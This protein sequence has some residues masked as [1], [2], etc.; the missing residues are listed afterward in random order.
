MRL[1]QKPNSACRNLDTLQSFLFHP[2]SHQP[3]VSIILAGYFSS[4][5]KLFTAQQLSGMSRF[6]G[7]F[8]LPAM[9]FKTLAT[10]DFS[11][12]DYAFV[13]GIFLAKVTMAMLV[14]ASTLVFEYRLGPG[15]R[16][17]EG[18]LRGERPEGPSASAAR[19]SVGIS[20]AMAL[21]GLSWVGRHPGDPVERFRAG[22]AYLQGPV[23]H[24][25]P[26]LPPSALRPGAHLPRAV[27]RNL[28][29]PHY[30]HQTIIWIIKITDF[31]THAIKTTLISILVTETRGCPQDQPDRFLPV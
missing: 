20:S 9:L 28:C 14:M 22:V 23:Q 26:H 7:T 18:G 30:Y 12:V 16:F 4:R 13:L 10:L 27:S 29:H 1:N 19:K 8:C 5:T 6:V 31:V 2:P 15:S 3:Q 25:Q 11:T 24:E 21:A 17:I